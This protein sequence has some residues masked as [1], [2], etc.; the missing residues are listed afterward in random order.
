VLVVAKILA[1]SGDVINDTEVR[2]IYNKINEQ[3]F[4]VNIWKGSQQREYAEGKK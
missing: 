3:Q 4:C 1:F 2:D